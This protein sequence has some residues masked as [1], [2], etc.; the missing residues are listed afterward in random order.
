MRRT[1]RQ[2]GFTLTEL[3]VVMGI[4]AMLVAITVPTAST[5]VK[6]N[7][8]LSCASNLQHL[9][10]AVKLY[11][12]DEGGPPPRYPE[13]GA[14]VGAGFRALLDTGYLRSDHVLHCPSDQPHG[15]GNPLFAES[16]SAEDSAANADGPG[17]YATFNNYKYLSCR[18]VSDPTDVDYRRQLQP[19]DEVSGLPIFS[20]GWHP[21]DTTLICWCNWHERSITKSGVGVYLALYWD[22]SA[23]RM[24]NVLFQSGATTPAAW[25]VHPDE[26]PT[27]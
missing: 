19:L 25:R 4:A 17:D 6:G 9:G 12:L 13:S 26:E 1:R 20:R 18:G 7:K 22:G 27:P 24:R 8:A 2:G 16:Y 14:L 21:D 15:I 23:R 11:M 5:M 3:L 10:Q